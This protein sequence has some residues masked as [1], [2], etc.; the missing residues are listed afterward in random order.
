MKIAAEYLEE[1]EVIRRKEEIEVE[2]EARIYLVEY[3]VRGE[4]S[5]L[6]N[7]CDSSG[8]Q[9]RRER[10]PR[11]AQAWVKG[12]RHLAPPTWPALDEC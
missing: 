1:T 4:R 6:S 2:W 5:D 11:F 3:S 8:I 12:G 9:L 10:V 7:G